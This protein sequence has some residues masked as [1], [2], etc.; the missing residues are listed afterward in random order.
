[1]ECI[2]KHY[3]YVNIMYIMSDKAM[4]SVIHS[5]NEMET[6]FTRVALKIFESLVKPITE[7]LSEVCLY[8]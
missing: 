1:M 4:F 2:P 5:T 7:Y 8:F 3:N 6:F